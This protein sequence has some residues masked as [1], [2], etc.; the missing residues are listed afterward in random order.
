[1]DYGTADDYA[2]LGRLEK[3]Y[4]VELRPYLALWDA[5]RVPRW[6]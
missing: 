3:Q 4:V 1:M 5:W 6:L 2:F